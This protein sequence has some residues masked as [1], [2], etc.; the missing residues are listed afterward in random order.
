MNIIKF[1][2]KAQRAHICGE[3]QS[4][5][6]RGKDSFSCPT[7]FDNFFKNKGDLATLSWKV[8]I[9]LTPGDD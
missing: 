2:A 1:R 3:V 6:N 9:D 4:S 7:K 5:I 8:F